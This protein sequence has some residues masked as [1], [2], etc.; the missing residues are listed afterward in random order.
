MSHFR[1]RDPNAQFFLILLLIF[2]QLVPDLVVFWNVTNVMFEKKVVLS[3]VT[4]VK[5]DITVRTIRTKLCM[6]LNPMR[7]D[8]VFLV[9]TVQ[10]H[11]FF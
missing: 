4:C 10:T 3:S 5:I 8:V 1:A 11:S 7:S 2:K 9:K 6:F